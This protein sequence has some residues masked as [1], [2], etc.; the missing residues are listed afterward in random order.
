MRVSRSH[1]RL[2]SLAGAV[3]GI[4]TL[5]IA[6]SAQAKIYPPGT[7]CANQPTIAERLLCGRQEFRRQSGTA[8]ETPD[9][10]P[11]AALDEDR[12]FPDQPVPPPAS[13][14]P[15]PEPQPLPRSA[16]PNQ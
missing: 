14:S 3:V 6:A 12:P 16:S 2:L 15:A 1:G 4:L 8:I 11:P 9:Q 5:P 13:L 10:T 7:D